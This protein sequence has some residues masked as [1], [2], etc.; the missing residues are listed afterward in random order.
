MPAVGS[1][2]NIS[3]PPSLQKTDFFTRALRW[4]AP[5]VLSKGPKA[6]GRTMVRVESV[7]VAPSFFVGVK[8][9]F[10]IF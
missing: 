7:V 2:Q 10:H 4:M 1:A 6:K 9:E 5:V 8:L 3:W